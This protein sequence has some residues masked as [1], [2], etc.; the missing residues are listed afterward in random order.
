MQTDCPEIL[1]VGSG[2]VTA[3]PGLLVDAFSDKSNL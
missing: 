1:I 3:V 2:P